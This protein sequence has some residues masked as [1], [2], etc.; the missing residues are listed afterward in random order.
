MELFVDSSTSSSEYFDHHAL[1]D[2]SKHNSVGLPP[3]RQR[4]ATEM[5]FHWRVDGGSH[6]DV[7]WGVRE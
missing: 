3:A 4:N 1:G 2:P 5:A 7:L 6:L